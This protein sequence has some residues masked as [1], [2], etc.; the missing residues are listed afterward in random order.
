[1]NFAYAKKKAYI[2]LFHFCNPLKAIKKALELAAAIPMEM[3]AICIK[4]I[5]VVKFSAANTK[6]ELY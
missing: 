6:L 4:V 1:M 5:R 3:L 2:E